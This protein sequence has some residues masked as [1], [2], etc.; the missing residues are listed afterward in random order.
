[1]TRK[2]IELLD[3]DKSM[4][5][6]DVT[7]RLIESIINPFTQDH[8]IQIGRAKYYNFEEAQALINNLERHIKY[9]D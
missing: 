7:N 4:L 1:M 2:E 3:L 8:Y 6:L 9:E 5:N